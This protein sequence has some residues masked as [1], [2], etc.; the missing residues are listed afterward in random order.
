MSRFVLGT[1]GG[2]MALFGEREVPPSA[3]LYRAAFLEKSQR[4][5]ESRTNRISD[6]PS[7]SCLN[8]ELLLGLYLDHDRADCHGG[9]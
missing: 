5:E 6:F 9:A 4:A 3:A 7:T 2:T 1:E 8:G